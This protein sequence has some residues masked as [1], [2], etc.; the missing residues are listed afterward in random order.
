MKM[1]RPILLVVFWLGVLSFVMGQIISFYP[2]AET[3]WFLATSVM[4][5]A[6]LFIHGK[7]YRIASGVLLVLS[8]ALATAGHKR[9]VDHKKWL[10]GQPK[11]EEQTK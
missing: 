4:L 10:S 9:G 1:A 3:Q 7:A 2:G 8:L 6:G 11:H 5:T